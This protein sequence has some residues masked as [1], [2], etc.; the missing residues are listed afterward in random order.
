MSN[1]DDWKIFTGE[2]QPHDKILKLNE[3][4]PPWREFDGVAIERKP[5]N[6]PERD[7]YRAE[8]FK[9]D[10]DLVDMVNASLYLR[11][12]LLITGRP[13]TGKSSLIYKVAYE[14]NL[15]KVLKWP[16]TSKTTLK[17]GLY[18]YDAIGRLQDQK[19]SPENKTDEKEINKYLRLGPLGTALLPTNR[20]RAL[21]I[22]EIDKSDFDLPNDLLNLFEEGE[23]TVP[24]LQR[25]KEP[26]VKIRTEETEDESKED[27]LTEIEKGKVKCSQFPFVVITSNEEREFPPAF[28]RRCLRYK[29]KDP[30]EAQLRDVVTVHLGEELA[31]QSEDIIKKFV[32]K[33]NKTH[34]LA[35]DQLLNAVFLVLQCKVPDGEREKLAEKLMQELS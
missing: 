12:P 10:K 32:E 17:D 14:L 4:Q 16:I 18:Q 2:D 19:F 27:Q 24:E 6:P 21:L 22:D 31:K 26:K 13:G 23:F 8:K 15:G 3:I 25:L 11:R 20:P 1:M 33:K 35:T 7:K 30:D 28:L 29:M 34:L 9:I 5:I